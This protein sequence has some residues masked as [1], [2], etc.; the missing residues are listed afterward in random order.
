MNFNVGIKSISISK[1]AKKVFEDLDEIRPKH[2]SFS[3]M[4]AV[5]ADE[6]I[7][8]HKRGL[9][10][11][12]DFSSENVSMSTPNFFSPVDDW[13]GYLSTIDNTERTR[14]KER[15]VQLQ[16]MMDGARL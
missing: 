2:I 5:T 3:L 7:K 9:V 10:K 6:Y 11:L 1:E 15:I 14:I 12:D 4:L 16:N 13:I 8:Q